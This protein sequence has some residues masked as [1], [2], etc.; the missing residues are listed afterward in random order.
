MLMVT[1][2][3]RKMKPN[4]Q[5]EKRKSKRISNCRSLRKTGR[6]LLMLISACQHMPMPKSKSQIKLNLFIFWLC[7]KACETLVP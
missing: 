2:V 3:L 7:C 6:C 5:K 1:S 4:R